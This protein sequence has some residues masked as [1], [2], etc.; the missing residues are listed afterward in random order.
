[1]KIKNDETADNQ[2]LSFISYDLEELLGVLPIFLEANL[3]DPRIEAMARE[4]LG[5]L[6]AKGCEIQEAD[7]DCEGCAACVH[8][9]LMSAL[10]YLPE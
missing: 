1:M 8:L 5:A 10:S 4:F 9:S 7:L 2:R 6:R 3:E